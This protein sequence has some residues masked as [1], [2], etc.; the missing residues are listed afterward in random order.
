MPSETIDR[1][2]VTQFDTS[3]RLA[4][5]QRQ[6]RLRGTVMDRGHI[7]GSAFTITNIGTTE[8]DEKVIR[9]GDTEWGDT[10]FGAR[11]VPMRDFFRALPLDRADIPKMIV[12]PVTGGQYMTT[13]MNAKN[14]KVDDIIYNAALNP[15]L[16]NDGSTTYD[17]PAGQIIAGGGTGLTKAKVIQAKTI[18]RANE[19]DSFEEG[20]ELYMLYNSVALTQILSD[21]TLTSADFLAGQMLQTGKMA[22]WMG[23]TWIPYERLKVSGGVYSTVAYTKDAIHFGDGYEQGDIKQRPDKQNAWQVSME[24]SYGAGRQD[25][26]KVVRIDFQ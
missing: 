18:M 6:S 9:L 10:L 22:N 11:T 17:L 23:F 12:N 19:V 2:F 4:A 7:T 15:M 3:L 8:L 14:R 16:S 1:A 24:A 25:E 21:T 5:Q 20:E 26:K 13:L